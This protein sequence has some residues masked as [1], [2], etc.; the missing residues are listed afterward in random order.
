MN[1]GLGDDAKSVMPP[2]TT[3]DMT[4]EELVRQAYAMPGQGYRLS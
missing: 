2:F 4:N 3:N 1:K